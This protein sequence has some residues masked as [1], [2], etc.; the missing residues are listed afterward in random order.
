[1]VAV[2]TGAKVFISIPDLCANAS[3]CHRKDKKGDK[4]HANGHTVLA[5]PPPRKTSPQIPFH[6]SAGLPY[7]SYVL[8]GIDILASHRFRETG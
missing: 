7:S 2:I 1:M 3:A 4:R 5:N 8:V 6:E